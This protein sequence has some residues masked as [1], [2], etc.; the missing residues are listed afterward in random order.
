MQGMSGKEGREY[1]ED[2][3]M[4][5]GSDCIDSCAAQPER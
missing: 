2:M 1:E 3:D 5:S 4:L